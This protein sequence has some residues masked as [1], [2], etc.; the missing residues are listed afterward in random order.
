MAT[1]RW[2]AERREQRQQR[3]TRLGAYLY[4]TGGKIDLQFD[5]ANPQ[6]FYTK[7]G[8]QWQAPQGGNWLQRI[9]GKS[10]HVKA[11]WQETPSR[12]LEYQE[13]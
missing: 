11:L 6:T 3:R 1:E 9:Q 8:W 13:G 12:A 10:R 5:P 4:G 2:L 7:S